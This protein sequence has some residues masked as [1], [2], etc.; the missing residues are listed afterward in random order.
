MLRI[1]GWASDVTVHVGGSTHTVRSGQ[2]HEIRRVWRVGDTVELDL[3]LRPRLMQAHP[4]V[5]ETRNQVAIV[6]GPLVYCLESS[7]LPDDVR[8]AD[9]LVS[10]AVELRA[11]TEQHGP[12]AGMTLLHGTAL[13]RAEDHG[14][15]RTTLSGAVSAASAR[16]GD[17]R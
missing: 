4:L 5:E 7:D 9:V 11:S 12:L 2:Y 6:R 17:A 8:L 16:D 1:P 3:P 14:I 15:R 10:R 13:A